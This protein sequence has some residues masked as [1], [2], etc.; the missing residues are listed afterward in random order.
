MSS[1]GPGG[2][3]G[4]ERS[5]ID[6]HILALKRI[7]ANLA[8]EQRETQKRAENGDYDRPPPQYECWPEDCDHKGAKKNGNVKSCSK[9][10]ATFM[11][12]DG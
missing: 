12:K 4:P 8:K 5:E 11:A 7:L 9:C 6:G 1:G 10:G 2:I 3:S